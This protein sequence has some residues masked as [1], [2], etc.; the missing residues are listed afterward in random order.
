[1]KPS[2]ERTFYVKKKGKEVDEHS[3]SYLRTSRLIP[4][5]DESTLR[6]KKAM[7][8]LNGMLLNSAYRTARI[9]TK[10]FSGFSTK[11]NRPNCKLYRQKRGKS[12]SSTKD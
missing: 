8:P 9:T 5:F 3:E 6:A 1:M 7:K 11:R 12:Q 4:G 2:F 10:G